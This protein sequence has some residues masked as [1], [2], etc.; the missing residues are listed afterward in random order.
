MPAVM[1]LRAG[2]EARCRHCRMKFDLKLPDAAMETGLPIGLGDPSHLDGARAL[3]VV[4]ALLSVLGVRA[5]VRFFPLRAE[6]GYGD[7]YIL[8][9]VQSF[10]RTGQI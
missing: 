10:Q 5:M 2:R 6:V 1:K 7:G 3:V 4:L 8:Y 9:D